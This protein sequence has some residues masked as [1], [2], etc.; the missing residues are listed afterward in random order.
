MTEVDSNY[1]TINNDVIAYKK[2]S[3]NRL[4]ESGHWWMLLLLL[5]V[6]LID[7]ED[8]GG[9]GLLGRSWLDAWRDAFPTKPY[10]PPCKNN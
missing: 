5:Y 4:H 7:S 1:I 6:L 8:L 10:A 2:R 3:G 9:G